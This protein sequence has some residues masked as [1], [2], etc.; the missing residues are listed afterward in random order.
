MTIVITVI[1][2]LGL[3][4]AILNM[5]VFM[6]EKNQGAYLGWFAASCYAILSL[7]AIW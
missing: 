1:I 3:I 7:L 6:K 5:I 4:A 2:S